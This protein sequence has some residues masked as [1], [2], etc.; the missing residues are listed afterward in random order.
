[1]AAARGRLSWVQRSFGK[2]VAVSWCGLDD[3]VW[4]AGTS[5]ADLASRLSVAFVAMASCTRGFD[6]LLARTPATVRA[7]D[8]A[9]DRCV[10]RIH[11]PR[12]GGY[13]ATCLG[14]YRH[15]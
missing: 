3:S 1:P 8:A 2:P 13:C 6:R 11:G 10:L 9:A 14:R 15:L 7:R 12:D 5:S 4:L